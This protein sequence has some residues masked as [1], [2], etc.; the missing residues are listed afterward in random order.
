MEPHEKRK[1]I[2]MIPYAE[3]KNYNSG[4]N[5]A[6]QGNRRDIYLK[7]CC[8]ACLSARYHNDEMTDVALVTN[9]DIPE[10]Y[11]QLLIRNHVLV[12][13]QDF[14]LFRFPES[15]TWSLA[16][17]KLCALYRMLDRFNYDYYAYL[18]SDVY[19][20]A[21]F[22]NIWAECDDNILLY[23]INHGLQVE[24]YNHFLKEIKSFLNTDKKITHFGGE[25]FA[26]NKENTIA[27]SR[28]CYEIFEEMNKDRFVTTHGDEFILSIAAEKMKL[29]VKNAGAYIFRFWT[30]LFRL[31]A[32]SYKNNAVT[33]I[34]VPDEKEA[35]MIKL[36]DQFFSKGINPTDIKVYSILHL[37]KT[38]LKIRLSVLKSRIL[39]RT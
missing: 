27:F 16:F 21:G 29:R 5:V 28:L 12:I 37:G 36:F 33:V 24:H 1:G 32:T 25:F 15:Y 6:D 10:K 39:K 22:E 2:L 20:Q 23:D 14:D 31:V 18:D 17:Y 9:I 3:I 8:V 4:V 7:N 13:H 11:Q 38:S 19:I 30:G 26:A 35:G 34:H